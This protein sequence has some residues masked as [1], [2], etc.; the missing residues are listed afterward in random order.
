MALSFYQGKDKVVTNLGRAKEDNSLLFSVDKLNAYGKFND[1]LTPF[2]EHR[3]VICETNYAQL[4]N[5]QKLNSK[6]TYY[7]PDGDLNI[8]IDYSH[9]INMTMV[10]NSL[11]IVTNEAI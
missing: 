8:G 2:S 3:D 1:T 10:G 11:T 6:Q 4:P 9:P 5:S 7:I